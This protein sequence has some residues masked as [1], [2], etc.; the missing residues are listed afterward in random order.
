MTKS[1]LEKALS[2]LKASSI[3]KDADEKLLIKMLNEY[4]S[5]SALIDII[6]KYGQKDE[7]KIF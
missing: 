6:N 5:V 1:V 2:G 7:Q 3:F 4:S